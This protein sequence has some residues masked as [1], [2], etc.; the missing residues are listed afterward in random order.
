MKAAHRPILCAFCVVIVSTSFYLWHVGVD[1]SKYNKVICSAL[2][3]QNYSGEE[4]WSWTW[5]IEYARF[6]T[7]GWFSIK[8]YFHQPYQFTA[9]WLPLEFWQFWRAFIFSSLCTTPNAIICL[10]DKIT[11]CNYTLSAQINCCR[12]KKILQKITRDNT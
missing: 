5:M 6:L 8:T 11:M 7:V 3:Y 4:S 1:T 9:L 2:C 12:G 10:S